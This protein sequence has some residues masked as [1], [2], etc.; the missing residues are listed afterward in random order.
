MHIVQSVRLNRFVVE[1]RTIARLPLEAAYH[2]ELRGT[3]TVQCQR[4]SNYRG[5]Y[6]LPSHV[7]TTFLQ[8]NHCPTVIASLPSCFFGRFKEAIGFLVLRTILRPMPLPIA[9][10]TDS[11]LTPTTFANLLPIL[12]MNI[13]RFYPFAT[14]SSRTI[15]TVF[16]RIL[17]KFP[18]PCPLEL[19]V[20]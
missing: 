10:T 7:I 2:T 1:P 4:C 14:T 3:A 13:A 6:D 8:L 12:L 11:R 15:Y 20:K 17:R 19:H 18:I 9:Q 16:S 5:K